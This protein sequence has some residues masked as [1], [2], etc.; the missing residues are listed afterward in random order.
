LIVLD[1]V[2][3]K[4][5]AITRKVKRITSII[6]LSHK[7]EWSPDSAR[8]NSVAATHADDFWHKFGKPVMR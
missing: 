8:T 3:N 4:C 1:A 7:S 5:H 2:K 6:G